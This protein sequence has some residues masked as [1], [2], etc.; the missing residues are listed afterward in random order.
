MNLKTIGC[1]VGLVVLCV[2]KATLVWTIWCCVIGA[3]ELIGAATVCW[4]W[5]NR[6]SRDG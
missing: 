3:L 4:V 2:I 1:L 6:V 5:R